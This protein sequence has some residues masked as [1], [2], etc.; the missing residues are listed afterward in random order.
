MDDINNVKLEIT[1][2]NYIRQIER[3]CKWSHHNAIDEVQKLIIEWQSLKNKNVKELLQSIE[4]LKDK[5]TTKLIKEEAI[6]E[7]ERKRKISTKAKGE[8]R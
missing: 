8:M 6:F 2:D 3:S 7:D 4:K 5:T 1:W